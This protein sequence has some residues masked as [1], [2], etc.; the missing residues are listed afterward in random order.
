MI[1]DRFPLVG[2]FKELEYGRPDAPPILTAVRATAAERE[3]DLV[4]YLRAGT[5]LVATPSAVPDVL[6]ETGA[7]IGGLHLLTDGQW[8]WYSD[9]AHYVGCYHVELDPVFIEHA[10]GN[11]WAVPQVGDEHLEAM[12][13]LLIGDE[14]QSN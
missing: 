8:L 10:H 13:A 1:F 7:L 3:D 5:V 4:R 2:G 6:S 14:D 11:N 12:V 9:L